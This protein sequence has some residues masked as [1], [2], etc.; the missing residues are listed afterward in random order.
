[1][2][3]QEVNLFHSH[4]CQWNSMFLFRPLIWEH[5]M[6]INILLFCVPLPHLVCFF[7]YSLQTTNKISECNAWVKVRRSRSRLGSFLFAKGFLCLI[8]PWDSSPVYTYYESRVIWLQKGNS[9]HCFSQIHLLDLLI[10]VFSIIWPPRLMLLSNVNRTSHMSR[11]TQKSPS[12]SI[13]HVPP[14]ETSIAREKALWKY[15]FV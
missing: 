9:H 4:T 8:S 12:G 7:I 15:A 1:M 13:A 11:N 14:R 5:Y 2:N 3:E 10:F 6:G